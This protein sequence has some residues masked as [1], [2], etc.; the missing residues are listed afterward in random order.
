M[1]NLGSQ[2]GPA[3]VGVGPEGQSL[4]TAMGPG[5]MG[6]PRMP[7]PG[8]PPPQHQYRGMLPPFVSF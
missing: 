2:G 6:M 7:G 3:G 4:N 8:N 1:T 5:P